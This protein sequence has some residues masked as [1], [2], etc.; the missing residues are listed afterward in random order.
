[1]RV[2]REQLLEGALA[3]GDL[4]EYGIPDGLRG[5]EGVKR[6]QSVFRDRLDR[7]WFSLNRG[8]SVV[9]PARL[10]RNSVPTMVHVQELSVDGN[11]LNIAN[12]T[13]LPGGQQRITFSFAGLSFSAPDRVRYRYM[14]DG[15]DH[16]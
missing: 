9:D 13:H 5:T 16:D 14:L 2:R 15:Y 3:D 6:H 11:Q 7:I 4:R 12:V 1:M 10:E 8:I